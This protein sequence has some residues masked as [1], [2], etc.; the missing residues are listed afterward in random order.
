MC[1]RDPSRAEAATNRVNT[2]DGALPPA[3]LHNFR[4]T[5]LCTPCTRLRNNHLQTHIF[6]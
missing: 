2:G 5:R 6:D 3:R 4:V 1:A